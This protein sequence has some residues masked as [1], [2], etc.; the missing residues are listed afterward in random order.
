MHFTYSLKDLPEIA[1]KVLLNTEHKT[2]LF[3]GEM[4]AGKTTLIKEIAKKIGVLET[5]SSP[6]YSIVN[7]YEIENDKLYH[8]DC[9][10]LNNTDEALDIGIEEYL[11]SGFWN[12]IEWPEKISDLLPT[13]K[14]EIELIKNKNGSR[15][16]NLKQMN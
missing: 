11:E 15:T 2:L 16:L 6:T 3:Y 9:Y 14:T 1:D 8:F 7:E 13:S 4:G 12:L 10:R 5:I